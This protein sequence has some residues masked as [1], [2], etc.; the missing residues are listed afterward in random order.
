MAIGGN[1]MKKIKI[2]F[3]YQCFPIW[4]YDNNGELIGNDLPKELIDDKQVEDAFVNIQSIYDSLF[5]D[6]TIEFKYI[7]FSSE[8][9]REE[10]L[11]IVDDAVNLLK[12]KLGDLY[13]IEKRVEV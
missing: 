11:K 2:Y 7:G 8:T 6:N 10:Y 9:E 1:F 3:D 12:I 5:T 4:I 13:I